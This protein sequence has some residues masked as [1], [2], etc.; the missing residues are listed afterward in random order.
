MTAPSQIGR[1]QVIGHLASGGMAEILLGKL[2]GPSGFERPVVIKRILPNLV[3]Q[4]SFVDMFLDEAKVVARIQH[5]NVVHVHELGNQSGELYMVMEYLQ[6]ETALNLLR[7]A[8]RND[9]PIHPVVA[10]HIV[11]QAAAGLHAAHELRDESGELVRLVHRDIS[12]HNIFITYTGAVKVLD[13][14][15]AKHDERDTATE[16][17]QLKGKFP[18]MSP[19]QCLGKD[20]DRRSDVFS[21]GIVLFELITGKRLFARET[22]LSTMQAIVKGESISPAKINPECPP[23]LAAVCLRALERSPEARYQT[24]ADMRRDLVSTLKAIPF[25]DFPE[26]ALAN[27]M[28]FLFRDRVYEKQQMLERVG[29]GSQITNVPQADVDNSVSLPGVNGDR[30]RV[31]NSTPFSVEAEQRDASRWGRGFP[32]IV[33]AAILLGVGVGLG[34]AFGGRGEEMVAASDHPAPVP[35]TEE[36]EPPVDEAPVADEAPSIA[37]TTET[38]PAPETETEAQPAILAPEASEVTLS[39]TTWPAGASVTIDGEER[40]VTPL[41]LSMPRT[42]EA[43]EVELARTGFETE[44]HSFVPEADGAI[45]ATLSPRR[46]RR[47]HGSSRMTAPTM[48]PSSASMSDSPFRRFN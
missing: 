26:E 16:A 40:G 39:L 23:E 5:P 46:S 11:A 35:S 43:V 25:D 14:G 36:E 48:D 47:R 24:A 32:L 38:A 20:V 17:G 19:E 18:Y 45:E 41:E 31:D 34:V 21:L 7:R 22:T 6:G 29:A 12:P 28:H 1:Y 13:F 42:G 37:A 44:S 10:G 2:V 15:I 30:K 33:G 4:Q 9:E 3:Q 8:K 27:Q